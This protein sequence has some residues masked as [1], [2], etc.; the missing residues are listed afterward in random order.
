[1]SISTANSSISYVGNAST[2][3]PYVVNYPFFDASDLKV[4]SVDAAGVSTLLAITTNYTVSGGNGSTGSVTTTAAIPAT[5]TVIITRDVPYTQLTSL[6]T[7]DRLPAK[8]IE[9]ALDKATMQ[10]QQL[11]RVV[12]PDTATAS[13]TAPYILSANTAGGAP[14]WQSIQTNQIATGMIQNSAVTTAKIADSSITSAKIADGTIQTVDIADG[15]I[16][17]AKIADGTIATV[18]IADAAITTAKIAAGA[19]ITADLADGAVTT[20][21]IADANVTT[22]KIA[23]ANVLPIKIGGNPASGSFVLGSSAGAVGWVSPSTASVADGAVT[24]AKLSTG[25]PAWDTS[26]FTT[27]G[28]TLKV[29]KQGGS[30]G[31]QIELA[32]GVDNATAYF[33]DVIG[34]SVTDNVLRVIDTQSTPVVRMTLDSTGNVGIGTSSPAAKLQIN[35]QDGFRFGTAAG[36]VTQMRFGSAATGEGTAELA[37]DRVAGSIAIS[38]GDTGGTLLE[39]LRIDSA[40]NVGI[41]TSSP[42]EKLAVAGWIQ[43]EENSGVVFGFSGC[44][45]RRLVGDGSLVLQTNQANLVLSTNNTARLAIGQD[46]VIN[47]QGNPITN[48]PTTAKAWVNF[49]GTGTPAIRSSY[50]TSSVTK[51]GTGDYQVN[52]ATAMSNANY[53]VA[54]TADHAG[55]KRSLYMDNSGVGGATGSVRISTATS[56]GVT[57]LADSSFVSVQI[58]GN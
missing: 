6:T 25:G 29:L 19:V 13:G 44:Y 3:T 50:N 45:A 21:K 43:T 30:E 28:H 48:S 58:F 51:I 1:M 38:H 39:R 22:S 17:S 49:N 14:V 20:T 46:G 24:P 23:D 8:T 54:G 55:S 37:Y 18:D 52:F 36:A 27:I 15:A 41:G 56:G 9:A 42:S 40:G 2:S 11:S 12:P 4:Y 33:L 35:V 34:S 16:T 57:A 7:G 5:S 31:G 47:A 32:R 10:A 53:T 26:G